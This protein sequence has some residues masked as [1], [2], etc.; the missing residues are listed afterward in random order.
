MATKSKKLCETIGNN[1]STTI[2]A[3]GWTP[4][5]LWKEVGGT[6]PSVYRACRGEGAPSVSLLCDIAEALDCTIDELVAA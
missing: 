6:K 1:I 5:R 2:A 4:Y 3:R